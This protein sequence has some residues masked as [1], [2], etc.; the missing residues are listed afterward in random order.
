MD[1][2][3]I[4]DEKD[5]HEVLRDILSKAYPDFRVLAS[6]F[7]VREGLE[8]IRKFNPELI[9]LDIEMRDG[10]GF[11]LLKELGDEPDLQVIFVTAH[12]HYALTA[13]RF[14]ALDYILKPIDSDLLREALERARRTQEKKISQ[15]QLQILWETLDKLKERKLPTRIGISTQEGIIY[16]TV[17]DII[18][19][20]A[21]KNYTQ[22][23]IDHSA[24]KILA[25]I[26]I[27]E[28]EEQ[29]KPY[30]EFMRVHRSHLVNLEYVEKYVRSDGGYLVLQ[31]GSKVAVSRIYKDDLLDRLNN[32]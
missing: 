12:K 1:T 27:G 28:Y 2:V 29:F 19:L 25:A 30:E 17:K 23:T 24:K 4:D 21:Q 13:I 3:I 11:D 5:S 10:T 18:R 31:D 22:F 7:G 14:G 9:F 32:L 15:Q 6:G 8:L 20:E 16:K 26:N